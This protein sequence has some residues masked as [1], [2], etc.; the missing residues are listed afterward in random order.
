[1]TSQLSIRET[2]VIQSIA[3][4]K[5]VQQIAFELNRSRHTIETHKAKAFFK[6]GLRNAVEASRYAIATGLVSMPT[7]DEFLKPTEERR[8]ESSTR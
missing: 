4:G 5:S 2:E 8:H 3:L 6:L 7:I 1:M